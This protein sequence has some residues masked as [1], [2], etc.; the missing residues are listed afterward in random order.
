[1]IIAGPGTGKTRTLT[2]RLAAGV[3]EQ[4]VPAEACLALTFTRRAA[5]E[6]RER[7]AGLLGRRA[8]GLT[9]TTSTGSG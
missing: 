5:E 9:V 8:A 7:L 4:G 3:A 1:M 2:H 6:M